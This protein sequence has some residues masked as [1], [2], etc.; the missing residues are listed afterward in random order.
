MRLSRN[1]VQLI[2][3]V[4]HEKDKNA[5]IYLFGSR[6]D[7]K[8]SG[9]DIDL[10]VLSETLGL[11]DK[12]NILGTIKKTIGDQK[13]DMILTNLEKSKSDPFISFNLKTAQAL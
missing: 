3:Q 4:I 10:I 1:E 13:I 2:T 7:N 6:T 9:G 8:K 11:E 12:L 5:L